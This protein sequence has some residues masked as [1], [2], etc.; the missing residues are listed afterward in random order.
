MAH[1]VSR[2]TGHFTQKCFLGSA[3]CRR[4]NQLIFI[5]LG[6]KGRQEGILTVYFISNICVGLING[7]DALLSVYFILCV[8]IFL[9][10]KYSWTIVS[11][12][13]ETKTL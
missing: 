3:S 2:E 12:S 8:C 13:S 1:K 7:L 9:F 11:G 10:K 4:S 6:K 5:C